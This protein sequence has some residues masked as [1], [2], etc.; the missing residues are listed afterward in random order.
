MGHDQ[1]GVGEALRLL[2]VVRRHEDRRALR[3]QRVD[4]RPELLPHLRVEADGRLVEEHEP[5][6]VDERARDQQPPAHAAGEL[7]DAAVAPV[8]EVRHL[9]R[10]LDRG[11]PLGAG[12]PVE[13]REDEQVLLDG[14]R[15]VEVVELR[16]DPAL[17]AGRLRLLGQP[18]AEHLELAFVRDRLRGEQAHGRRL[19]RAVGPEQADAG[20]LRDVEVEPV[21]RR[22]RPVALD[23]AAQADGELSLTPS[24]CQC[25]L[26]RLRGR[27]PLALPRVARDDRPEQDRAEHRRRE[28]EDRADEEG[29]VVAAVERGGSAVP[30][31]RRFSVREAARLART[32][33]PT[34]PPIMNDV[35]T[36]PEASPASSGSTP[37]MAA[38][39]IGLKAIPAPTP[40]EIVGRT[41]ITKLPSTGAR[42]SS[43]SAT[44]ISVEPADERR[45]DTETHHEPVRVERAEAPDDGRGQVREADLERRV[46]EDPLQVERREEE[47]REHPR[48][49][50]DADAVGGE[51]FR[52]R[53][54]PSGTSGELDPRLD[55][56]EDEQEDG[57]AP[58]RPSVSTDVH[59]FEFPFTMA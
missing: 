7:V 50:E 37:P 38:S 54:R 42:A 22:D 52:F 25:R 56:E 34:A 59:P 58:R 49:H 2:D 18:E 20:A 4:E 3:A 10:A 23:D 6:P 13:V 36:T 17:R 40:T 46:A 44:A 12:D 28:G 33:R 45:L 21:D 15:H 5:R 8:D 48:G 30:P 39:R 26:G 51:T 14:Q 53:K 16:H 27:L 31:S 35:L 19:A 47:V 24:A 57:G 11:A 55:H 29:D 1:D 43:S 32:A 9:E 41:S